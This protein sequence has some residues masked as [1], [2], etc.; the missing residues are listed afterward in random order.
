MPSRIQEVVGSDSEVILEAARLVRAHRADREV[1][2][3]YLFCWML[4]L[5]TLD[6]TNLSGVLDRLVRAAPSRRDQDQLVGK[7][8]ARLQ[9][10]GGSSMAIPKGM[11]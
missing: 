5:A 11:H 7:L 8:R 3:K 1:A 9:A 4:I 2:K 6:G 10:E